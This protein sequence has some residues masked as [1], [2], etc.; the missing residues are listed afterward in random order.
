MELDQVKAILAKV[1]AKGGKDVL[2]TGVVQNLVATA[3][4]IR[5][6]LVYDDSFGMQDKAQIEAGIKTALKMA[7]WEKSLRLMPI[8][9]MRPVASPEAPKGGNVG[10]VVGLGK[11]GGPQGPGPQGPPGPPG[12]TQARVGQQTPSG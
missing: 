11:K 6:D 12:R 3:D 4:E 7:G 8:M 1:E 9:K 5:M 10:P 2:A